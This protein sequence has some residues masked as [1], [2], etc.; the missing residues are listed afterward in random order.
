MDF[1]LICQRR[2]TAIM[3]P[4][5]WIWKYSHQ[6]RY[7]GLSKLWDNHFTIIQVNFKLVRVTLQLETPFWI[8]KF[9]FM[10]VGMTGAK[11]TTG[12]SGLRGKADIPC[13]FLSGVVPKFNN[14]IVSSPENSQI[15]VYHIFFLIRLNCKNLF[16][17]QSDLAQSS[18][19]RYAC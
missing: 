8:L 13:Y 1:S 10:F 12:Q 9:V 3:N 17:R 14:T 4:P 16:L 18:P 5:S 11:R 2:A 7:E 15:H 19:P 6:I